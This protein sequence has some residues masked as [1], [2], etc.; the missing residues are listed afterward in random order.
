M[1]DK[2]MPDGVIE[3]IDKVGAWARTQVQKMLGT[4]RQ[5]RKTAA[6][7]SEDIFRAHEYL[8]ARAG[9]YVDATF[10]EFREGRWRAGLAVCRWLHEAYVTLAWCV[11]DA[12]GS[13]EAHGIR[14]RFERWW[15]ESLRQRR[16]RLKARQMIW[17]EQKPALDREISIIQ[18][19][20]CQMKDVPKL[21]N[22]EEMVKDIADRSADPKR[23]GKVGMYY[24][25]YRLF[26]ASAH[27]D[28]DLGTMFVRRPGSTVSRQTSATPPPEAL[29]QASQAVAFLLA[30]V[31]VSIGC[32]PE[33]FHRSYE[34]LEKP[35]RR[36][37]VWATKQE[38]P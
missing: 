25:L 29:W 24:A 22:L 2:P 17:P 4:V 36:Y 8:L 23:K 1:D 26:C 9:Q 5:K 10:A 31:G 13:E 20:M 28:L 6:Q 19:Q 30:H 14:Q 33:A 37:E 27:P 12:D 3:A 15:K 21:P 34:G 7:R 11:V 35:L 32:D 16:N 18:Q 38:A